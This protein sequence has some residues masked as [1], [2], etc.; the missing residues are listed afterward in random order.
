MQG[1]A[2]STHA[3]KPFALLNTDNAT[4]AERPECAVSKGIG[5]KGGGKTR[6]KRLPQEEGNA[7]RAARSKRR[8][9][10]REEQK[11][12]ETGARVARETTC[13]ATVVGVACRS[14]SHV[15]IYLARD[16]HSNLPFVWVLVVLLLTLKW[17]HILQRML[18][19]D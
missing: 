11:E 2:R 17:K 7:K 19:T 13:A 6:S 3:Q 10:R 8:G 14:S 16:I 5:Q 9:R 18:G 1:R 12:R 15:D 4:L